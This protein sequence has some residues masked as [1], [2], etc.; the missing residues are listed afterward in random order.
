MS[1]YVVFDWSGTHSVD[2][3]G[4]TLITEIRPPLLG[5]KLHTAAAATPH[6]VTNCS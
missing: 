1:Y 3:T 6:K 5:L 4:L 2:Q